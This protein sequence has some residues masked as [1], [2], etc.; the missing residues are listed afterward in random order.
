MSTQAVG[1]SNHDLDELLPI[2]SALEKQGIPLASNQIEFSLLR[3]LPKT[4]GLIKACSKLGIGILAYSPL[5]MGRLTGT[6]LRMRS[7]MRYTEV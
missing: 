2:Y 4:S 1:V 5:G 6:S 3:Q 7:R